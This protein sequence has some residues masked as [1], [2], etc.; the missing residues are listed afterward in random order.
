LEND[1]KKIDKGEL[2]ILTERYVDL[3]LSIDIPV[4]RSRLCVFFQSYLDYFNRKKEDYECI[5]YE[6]NAKIIHSLFSMLMYYNEAPGLSYQAAHCLSSLIRYKIYSSIVDDVAK[7]ILPDLIKS[8][9]EIQI[10]IFFDVLNNIILYLDVEDKVMLISMELS[11]RIL[12]EIK[13]P[14]NNTDSHY[15]T[16]TNKCFNTLQTII[17]KY[18]FFLGDRTDVPNL[19]TFEQIINPLMLYLKNPGKIYFDDD[20][21]QLLT[22]LIQNVEVISPY[23]GEVFPILLKYIKKHNG[24]N[25]NLYNCLLSYLHYSGEFFE[26]EKNLALLIQMIQF[27]ISQY[28]ELE[29]SGP[30]SA[31]LSRITLEVI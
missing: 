30:Y 16:Y 10:L 11:Q 1:I 9:G 4:I 19:A 8:I 17:E 7:K 24:I 20:L 26:N 31:L 28:D 12:T 21:I 13:S 15:N 25:K 23:I 5:N 29:E 18:K 27:G 3:L 14:V 6:T 22:R 2:L